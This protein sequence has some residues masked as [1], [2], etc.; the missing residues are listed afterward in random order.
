M[1]AAA[2]ARPRLVEGRRGKG[3]ASPRVS[4][5]AADRFE[6]YSRT[7]SHD[8]EVL[9][10]IDPHGARRAASSSPASRAR[11][12]ST[13]RRST[14]KPADRSATSA[15]STRRDRNTVVADVTG[16]YYPVQ[17][18]RAHKVTAKQAIRVGDTRGRGRQH[19]ASATP[20]MRNHTATHLLHAALREV[21]GKHVKQA[22]SLVAPARLRFDFSHFTGVADEELQDIEDIVNREVLR[23][24]QGRSNPRRAR[25]TWP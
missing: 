19:R 23:N 11:S 18:V 1:E 15:G 13:T 5:T 17:G 9:A 6:G 10:I 22:G 16:C 2:R 8:S 12:F 20:P 4:R 21:L 14:P 24:A 3:A 7:E 25:S